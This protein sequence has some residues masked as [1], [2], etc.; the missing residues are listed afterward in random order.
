[1]LQSERECHV[2]PRDIEA[3]CG[4]FFTGRQVVLAVCVYVC[5]ETVARG[6]DTLDTQ[7]KP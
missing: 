3:L 6:M 7:H 5:V 1:M 2:S 4:V